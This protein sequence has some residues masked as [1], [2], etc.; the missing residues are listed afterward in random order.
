MSHDNYQVA[1]MVAMNVSVMI[2]LLFIINLVMYLYQDHN[3][4]QIVFTVSS[5]LENVTLHSHIIMLTCQTSA[6]PV[7]VK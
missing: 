6:F 5:G 4:I 7:L 1:Q 3:F 2:M